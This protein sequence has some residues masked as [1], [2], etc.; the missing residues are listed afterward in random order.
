MLSTG[1]PKSVPDLRE[2]LP[3]SPPC[4]W[5]AP[6]EGRSDRRRRAGADT[7]APGDLGQSHQ[8][9]PGPWCPV[10]GGGVDRCC[11]QQRQQT[12]GPRHQGQDLLHPQGN[13]RRYRS[14]LS[15]GRSCDGTTFGLVEGWHQL[16]LPP[17]VSGKS[18]RAILSRIPHWQKLMTKY[19]AKGVWLRPYSLR[20]MFSIRTHGIVKDDTLRAAVMGHTVAVHHRSYWTTEWSSVRTPFAQAGGHQTPSPSKHQKEMQQLQ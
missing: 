1:N 2:G 19:E 4:R 11:H 8:D 6:K 12:S 13:Q 18:L 10:L 5:Q 3:R 17:T 9:L 14:A 15:G 16:K 7:S 20:D